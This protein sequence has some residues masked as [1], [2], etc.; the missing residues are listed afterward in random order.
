MKK[1]N[2]L[3]TVVLLCVAIV[4]VQ[5][6]SQ[7]MNSLDERNDRSPR[8][9]I[10]QY[11]VHGSYPVD[12]YLWV[13]EHCKKLRGLLIFSQNVPE[14]LIAGHSAIRAACAAN[15]LGIFYTSLGFMFY[16]GP[17]TPADWSNT[18]YTSPESVKRLQSL[19]DLMAK[20]SGFEEVSTIPWIPIG[21]S[22]ARLMVK[23]V[24]NEKPERCIAAIVSNDLD[25]GNDRTV[26]VLMA[27]GT[28]S[29]WG[30]MGS[31]IRSQWNYTG[32]YSQYCTLRAQNK[33]WPATIICEAGA[34]HFNCT[35]QM[36]QYYA[37]YIDCAA[38]AR[39][40]D[41]GSNN[42]KSIDAT[43]TGYVAGLLMDNNSY[44]I[45]DV[46]RTK[47]LAYPW[48]F[49]QK[50]AEM[51][52]TMSKVNWQASTQL[53]IVEAVEGCTVNPWANNSVTTITV[54]TD[55]VFSLRPY[56]LDK[57]PDGFVGAG[58]SLANSGKEPAVEWL[59]GF[60]APLGNNRF[61]IELDRNYKDAKYNTGSNLVVYA[62]SSKTVRYSN[63][64]LI[65]NVVENT[66]GTD[67]SI[68]FPK[69]DDVTSA[70]DPIALNATASS[71]LPVKYY[72]EYGPAIIMN[73]KVVLKEIPDSAKYPIEVK[74]VAWQWGTCS[75]SPAYNKAIATQI[76]NI[77]KPITPTQIK[78]NASNT[79]ISVSAVSN[80]TFRINNVGQNMKWSL[81]DIRGMKRLAGEGS[82]LD[83]T[84]LGK[85]VYVVYVN[86]T[87][88]KILR[89]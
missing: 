41:D 59:S 32:Y 70:S 14:M 15:D 45:Y 73:N 75:G 42:L 72:V 63:Q 84:K 24:V 3:L 46:T 86:N 17:S 61:C 9:Q 23:A 58:S 18:G 55:S 43:T 39:L 8:N 80:N 20:K 51:A 83:A 22:M 53:P 40:S 81:Y 77:V 10:Y 47:R 28:G 6:V 76:F 13:P 50:S 88:L 54:K 68:T 21:E 48:F 12:A 37:Y 87:S 78:A 57:I 4:K 89:E 11:C 31:D 30:Q 38:K 2:F 19:L 64:P 1:N 66:G 56:L 25:A 71:G 33:Q 16:G 69:I 49:D 7:S 35:E 85:G 65:T 74:V 60:L 26:P 29:E 67:Q 79:K 52:Q 5:A 27:Q 82:I 44:P 62:D 36:L 34:G